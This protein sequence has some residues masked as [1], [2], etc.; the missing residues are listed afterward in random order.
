MKVRIIYA[1]ARVPVP[2]GELVAGFVVELVEVCAR[3]DVPSAGSRFVIILQNPE[4]LAQLQLNET[5]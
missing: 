2:R 3:G 4:L 5:V 1:N